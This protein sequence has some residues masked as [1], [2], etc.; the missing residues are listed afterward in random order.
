MNHSSVDQVLAEADQWAREHPWHSRLRGWRY[1]A[2]RCWVR[3]KREPRHRWERARRGFSRMDVW[4][5][6]HYIAGVI[7]AACDQL[8]AGHSHPNDMTAEEWETFLEGIAVE[9]RR[10]ADSDNFLDADAHAAGVA[11]MHRFADRFSDMWD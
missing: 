5:F 2:Q 11:A 6:D 1:R 10:Y 4:G 8:R 3:L 7:A 9:L